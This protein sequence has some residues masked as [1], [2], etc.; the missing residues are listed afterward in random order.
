MH[1][2]FLKH[3]D[4]YTE[5]HRASFIYG[6]LSVESFGGGKLY[7]VQFFGLLHLALDR[8]SAWHGAVEPALM[9][10]QE[11]AFWSQHHCQVSPLPRRDQP[12]CKCFRFLL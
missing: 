2:T 1:P 8:P 10:C 6:S 4:A 5:F 9:R 3:V 12:L 11:S 7:H